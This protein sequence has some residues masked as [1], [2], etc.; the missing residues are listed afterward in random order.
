MSAEKE[1]EPGSQ[2]RKGKFI[3][4]RWSHSFEKIGASGK[5]EWHL[6]NLVSLTDHSDFILSLQGQ[7]N[8]PSYQ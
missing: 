8:E 1:R 6:G 7:H 2:A 5:T 3:R 4:G